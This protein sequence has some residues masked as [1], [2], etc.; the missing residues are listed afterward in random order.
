METPT[1]Y[2]FNHPDPSWEYAEIYESLDAIALS[3]NDFR[4]WLSAHEDDSK[5]TDS[6]AKGKLDNIISSLQELRGLF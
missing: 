6:Q 4:Q 2:N 3:M 5:E 1:T